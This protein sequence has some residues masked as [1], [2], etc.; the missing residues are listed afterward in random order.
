ML[1]LYDL[2]DDESPIVTKYDINGNE[3]NNDLKIK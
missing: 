2:S 1:E 3:M